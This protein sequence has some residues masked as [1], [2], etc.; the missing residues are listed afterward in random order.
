M[1]SILLLMRLQLYLNKRP[2]GILLYPGNNFQC[3][4]DHDLN[5][6]IQYATINKAILEKK[7]KE[8]V[9]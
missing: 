4:G 7:K 2:C 3:V 5:E 6:I 8:Y 9:F 1:W